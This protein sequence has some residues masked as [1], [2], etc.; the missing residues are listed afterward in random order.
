MNNLKYF[1]FL[2][3]VFLFAGCSSH[4]LEFNGADG[5]PVTMQFHK[6]C[7]QNTYKNDKITHH[8]INDNELIVEV[9]M[10]LNC[11][12][13][14][15]NARYEIIKEPT[16]KL[17]LLYDTDQPE[18]AI[19]TMCVCTNIM[20]YHFFNLPRKKYEYNVKL[21]KNLCDSIF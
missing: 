7:K 16:P 10:S 8:W 12:K 6:K 9:Y 2:L 18:C 11:F 21:N 13:N 19:H 1:S 5:T 17:I 15:L 4:Q 20:A 3:L 14:T